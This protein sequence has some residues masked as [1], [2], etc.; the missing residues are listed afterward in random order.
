MIIRF[1][2]LTFVFLFLYQHNYASQFQ[3]VEVLRDDFTGS[4]SGEEISTTMKSS[5]AAVTTTTM[6]TQPNTTASTEYPK[7]KCLI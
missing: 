3:V 5:T 1:K 4:G 7:S 2:I 6:T